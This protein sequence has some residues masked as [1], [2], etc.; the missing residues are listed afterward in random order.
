MDGSPQVQPELL[1]Q[2]LVQAV[3]DVEVVDDGGR[4]LA[5]LTIP[6]T[7]RRHVHEDERDE[8]DEK[9]DGDHPEQAP[10]YIDHQGG[11]PPLGD[12][13]EEGQGA[14]PKRGARGY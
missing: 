5:A 12:P 7:T 4:E 9:E 6:R 3:L 10:D 2:R 8:D 11:R 1:P 13:R 14:P